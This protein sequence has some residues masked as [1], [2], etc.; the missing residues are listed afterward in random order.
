MT[1]LV[2]KKEFMRELEKIVHGLIQKGLIPEKTDVKTLV[3]SV[4]NKLHA[5]KDLMLDASDLKNENT[6][7]SLGLACMAQANPNN[8]LDYTFLF[9]N[10]SKE[11]RDEFEKQLKNLFTEIL[12]LNP[13]LTKENQ[14]E[15]E[16]D[17]NLLVER[18]TDKLI[19]DNRPVPE[20][21]SVFDVVAAGI[22]LL[23][24][25]RRA[26]YGVDTTIA[27]G[28]FIPPQMTPL[29][30]QLDNLPAAGE[31]Y[32]AH[33]QHP[34]PGEPDPLGFKLVEILE[35]VAGGSNI[36]DS[37]QEANLLAESNT[38]RPKPPGVQA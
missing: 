31:S 1:V 9:K 18:F 4:Y 32:E 37:F 13:K 2:D 38:P 26:T 35:Q 12:K 10:P 6:Q 3:E 33:K 7:K 27:G 25:Q 15:L 19:K 23:S 24:E 29:A 34:Q 28:V 5:D 30:D 14:K 16:H 36:I 17:I 8:K 20:N 11:N 21:K 22:D